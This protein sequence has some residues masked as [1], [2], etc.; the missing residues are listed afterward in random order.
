MNQVMVTDHFKVTE[1]KQSVE[2][3]L[4]E[5]LLVIFPDHRL[6]YPTHPYRSYYTSW[7]DIDGQVKH[8]VNKNG[9]LTSTYFGLLGP[10]PI[11]TRKK[12]MCIFPLGSLPLTELVG[13]VTIWYSTKSKYAKSVD[14]EVFGR[15]SKAKFLTFARMVP[16][17]IKN[18]PTIN[19]KV[20]SDEPRLENTNYQEW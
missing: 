13:T 17:I 19:V 10:K 15:N 5:L 6:G 12:I 20:V 4:L 14:I 16:K 3:E 9:E 11:D 8:N 2:K 1:D 18:K 7:V